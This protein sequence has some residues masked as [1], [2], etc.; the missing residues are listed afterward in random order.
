MSDKRI[1]ELEGQIAAL[2]FLLTLVIADSVPPSSLVKTYLDIFAQ[3]NI[4]ASNAFEKA[5]RETLR[6]VKDMLQSVE[7]ES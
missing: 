2:R 7:E 1:S 6:D 5:R 4:D 3:G